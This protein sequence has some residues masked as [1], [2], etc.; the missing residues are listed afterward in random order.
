M[1]NKNGS[2][3]SVGQKVVSLVSA[4]GLS[5]GAEYEVVGHHVVRNF[6]GGY[7]QYK[8]QLSPGGPVHWVGN[9]HLILTE[10]K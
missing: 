3:F 6:L 1:E 5:K 8:L 7:T 2:R 10:V 9:G 4:Q